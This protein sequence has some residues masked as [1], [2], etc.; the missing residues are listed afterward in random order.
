MTITSTGALVDSSFNPNCCWKAANRS[1]AASGL[2]AAGSGGP[3][4]SAVSAASGVKVNVKSYFS[5]RPDWSTTGLSN[6]FCNMAE[7]CDIGEFL[8]VS[9]VPDPVLPKY[10]PGRPFESSWLLVI[11]DPVFA[12]LIAYTERSVFSKWNLSW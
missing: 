5:E 6:Q 12:I 2:S 10:H 4:R 1:G 7:T 9:V 3:P 11:F 8:K